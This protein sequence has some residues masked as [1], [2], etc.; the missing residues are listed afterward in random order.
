MHQLL[1]PH[2]W[3][4]LHQQQH[5]QQQP[6]RKFDFRNKVFFIMDMFP[7]IFRP[8]TQPP[9]TTTTISAPHEKCSSRGVYKVWNILRREEKVWRYHFSFSTRLPIPFRALV[10]SCATKEL[11]SLEAAVRVY[12]SH[13]L[14][15][16]VF[17]V[18]TQ[19]VCL[20]MNLAQL[21]TIQKMLFFFQIKKI[22][23]SNFSKML[24]Q[25]SFS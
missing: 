6:D 22:V 13:G 23:K 10:I 3:L 24:I 2:R 20:T 11:L 16:V 8:V 12:T 21:K 5:Q 7:Y 9:P 19:I 25:K 18:Q 17:A 1:H 14:N 4:S 15:C